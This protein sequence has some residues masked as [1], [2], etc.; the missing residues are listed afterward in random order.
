MYIAKSEAQAYVDSAA[1]SAARYLDGTSDGITKANNGVAADTGKWRF[2]TSTFTNVTTA[3]G[4][5][6]TGPWTTTPP[7]PPT[8]Y[9]YAQVST[10]LSMPMYLI[11][12]VAGPTATIGA[13]AIAGRSEL[14]SLRYGVFPF[15]PIIRTGT[16][17]DSSGNTY[18]P[19]PDDSGDQFGYRIGKEYTLRWGSPGDRTD[20]GTDGDIDTKTG[21]PMQPMAR[22]GSIR[23]YCCVSNSASSLREAIVSGKTDTETIGDNISMEDGAKNTELSAIGWRTDQ[24]SDIN[25][26][27][28][29]DYLSRGNGNNARVVVVPVNTGFATNYRLAG[30]AA[31]FLKES[32]Y[33]SGLKGNDS[34]CAIYIGAWT[35]GVPPAAP[36]SGSGAWVLKLFQ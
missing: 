33:Y 13:S 7:D 23:G 14:T 29:T 24:D 15:S 10:T 16:Y 11:R 8:G 22:N 26:T 35:T 4:K 32:R 5:T 25:S 34:A 12:V 20:C 19:I 36:G 31:F 2:D 28:Y 30:F 21:L 3:Y 1:L 27:N 17:T 6:A 18:S 9:D